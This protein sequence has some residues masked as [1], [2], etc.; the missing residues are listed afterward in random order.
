MWLKLEDANRISLKLVAQATS[1]EAERRHT[2]TRARKR[3]AVVAVQLR[4]SELPSLPSRSK[5]EPGRVDAIKFY[6]TMD[7]HTRA[8]AEVAAPIKFEAANAE[9]CSNPRESNKLRWLLSLHAAP[10]P[11]P[12]WPEQTQPVPDFSLSLLRSRHHIRLNRPP[13]GKNSLSYCARFPPPDSPPQVNIC[14]TF[15]KGHL[16]PAHASRF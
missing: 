8:N 10:T 14:P 4:E 9:G 13:E 15:V 5:K 1:A 7:T 11:S 2:G 6:F 3:V 16:L 12:K